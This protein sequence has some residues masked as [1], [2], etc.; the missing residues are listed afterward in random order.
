MIAATQIELIKNLA[1]YEFDNK[2]YDFHNNY[3]CEKILYTN[4]TFSLFFKSVINSTQPIIEFDDVNVSVIEF[5]K[6]VGKELTLDLLY[7][8]RYES[9][10]ELIEL[11]NDG[12]G[13]FYLE[14][15]EGC[16][17]EFWA[18]GISIKE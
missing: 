7:R 18:K 2:Y 15:Y 11:S 9:N 16:K 13:Y 3:N 10:G 17:F 5:G 14:F 1:Q 8:G 12:K 4:N 6:Q